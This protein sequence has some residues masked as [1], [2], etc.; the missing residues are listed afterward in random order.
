MKQVIFNQDKSNYYKSKKRELARKDQADRVVQ[1]DALFVHYYG[2]SAYLTLFPEA[3]GFGI[4]WHRQLLREL[5]ILD[6][7]RLANELSG[8]SMAHAA[9]KSKKGSRM[10]KRMIKDLLRR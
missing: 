7:K 3:I 10:F 5:Q 8:A 1:E 4:N 2:M 9:N 6:K